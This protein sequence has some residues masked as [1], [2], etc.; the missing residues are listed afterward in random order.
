MQQ[1]TSNDCQTISPTSHQS[2][3][4]TWS[5]QK[6]GCAYSQVPLISTGEAQMLYS[7][8]PGQSKTLHLFSIPEYFS[9]TFPSLKWHKF[10]FY[11]LCYVVK[12]DWERRRGGGITLCLLSYSLSVTL[13]VINI[14]FRLLYAV[15]VAN[16]MFCFIHSPACQKFITFKK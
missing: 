8:K 14:F 1:W 16:T 9:V 11:F 6:D 2:N 13:R 10:S 7:K 5:R 3:Y 15:N 12:E 4:P